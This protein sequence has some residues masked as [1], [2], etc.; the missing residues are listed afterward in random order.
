MVLRKK[1]CVSGYMIFFK[2]ENIILL[3][4][5]FIIIII[6]MERYPN[7][8]VELGHSLEIPENALNTI[9]FGGGGGGKTLGMVG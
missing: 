9:M 6:I 4:V 3:I 5:F 7:N 8:M 1:L 2:K